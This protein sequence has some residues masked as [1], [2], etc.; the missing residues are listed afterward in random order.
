M[1]GKRKQAGSE[2]LCTVMPHTYHKV[3]LQRLSLFVRGGRRS[4]SNIRIIKFI[5]QIMV[6]FLS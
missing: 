3:Y 1:E 2:G 6:T 4:G 5:F